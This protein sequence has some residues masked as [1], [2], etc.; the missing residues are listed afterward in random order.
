MFLRRLSVCFYFIKSLL[1]GGK[2]DFRYRIVL[3]FL[4]SCFL[5]L[6]IPYIFG[7]M[8]YGLFLFF[9]IFPLFMGL[10]FCRL[11]EGGASDFF[12]SF[13]PKGTPLWIAPFVCL[14]ETLRYI[15]RPF[16][17]MVR[18]FVNISMGSLGGYVLGLLCFRNKCVLLFLILLFFYEIFV[19]VVH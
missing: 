10:F 4:L 1:S 15:V 14:A 3:F 19:A 12:S 18:P 2:G 5:C 8:G 6:R 13:I 9:I 7:L 17:L 11:L 16:V